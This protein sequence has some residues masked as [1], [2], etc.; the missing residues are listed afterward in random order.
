MGGPGSGRKKGSSGGKSKTTSSKKSP[1]S[2]EE[3]IKKFREM[4]KARPSI[5]AGSRAAKPKR[6][7]TFGGYGKR[8]RKGSNNDDKNPYL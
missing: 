5:K 8:K 2:M 4:E 7:G 6:S 1:L 3:K